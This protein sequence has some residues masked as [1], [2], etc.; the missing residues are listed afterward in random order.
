MF[1]RTTQLEFGD[2]DKE[3]SAAA[4]QK[5]MELSKQEPGFIEAILMVD[6]TTEK[7]ISISFWDTKE[8][9]ENSGRKGPGTL[10]DR[11]V[12]LLRPYLKA[13]PIFTQFE[14]RRRYK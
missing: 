12:P 2:R 6:P 8:N 9:S 7:A 14:V 5:T 11:A 4:W 3:E 1:S 13:D 10:I